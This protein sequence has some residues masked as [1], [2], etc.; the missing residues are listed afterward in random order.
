MSRLPVL[1]WKAPSPPYTTLRW[2]RP[3]SSVVTNRKY[4][5]IWPP[6]G[7]RRDDLVQPASQRAE[8]RGKGQPGLWRVEHTPCG[9]QPTTISR[10]RRLADV[11]RDSAPPVTAN[12]ATAGG[13]GHQPLPAVLLVAGLGGRVPDGVAD[14]PVRPPGRL[15]APGHRGPALDADRGLRWCPGLPDRPGRSGVAGRVRA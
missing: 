6:E 12:R 2:W 15:R 14:L 4:W 5:R 10:G 8:S 9:S 7:A 1:P 13:G 11:E 3:G